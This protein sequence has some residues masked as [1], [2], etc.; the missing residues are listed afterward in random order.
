MLSRAT[1]S[2]ETKF[3]KVLVM[4]RLT[5]EGG[6]SYMCSPCEASSLKR[7]AWHTELKALFQCGTVLGAD[8][9][10]Q[11]LQ[12]DPLPSAFVAPY[13]VCVSWPL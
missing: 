13:R 12:L 6:S 11:A 3:Q 8:L 10:A 5:R 1:K 7:R 2:L 9:Q 4:V